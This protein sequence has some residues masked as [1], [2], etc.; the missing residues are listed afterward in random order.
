MM[1]VSVPS[2]RKNWAWSS[3]KTTSSSSAS[4][5]TGCAPADHTGPP[6]MSR[7]TMKEPQS[8]HVASSRHRVTAMSR[9]RL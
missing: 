2:R 7:K 9:H 4:L 8:S 6:P 5:P 1:V 3:P